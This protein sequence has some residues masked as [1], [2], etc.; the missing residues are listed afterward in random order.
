MLWAARRLLCTGERLATGAARRLCRSHGILLMRI[1]SCAPLAGTSPLPHRSPRPALT[2]GS[3]LGVCLIVYAPLT[4][5]L[6]LTSSPLII[7]RFI[8]HSALAARAQPW[9]GKGPWQ[10]SLDLLQDSAYMDATAALL[11]GFDASHPVVAGSATL[12][13]DYDALKALI[14]EGAK[15]HMLTRSRVPH[16]QVLAADR[17]VRAA[18]GVYQRHPTLAHAREGFMHARAQRQALSS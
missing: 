6:A 8:L 4:W 15:R 10:I 14:R 17:A 16:A 3:F 11:D 18:L 9:L 2:A 13:A 12:G 5:A 1:A 7:A